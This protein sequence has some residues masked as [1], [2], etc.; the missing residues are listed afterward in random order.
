MY[1]W[2]VVASVGQLVFLMQTICSSVVVERD[3]VG[4]YMAIPSLIHSS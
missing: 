4:M 2:S 3:H 1:M